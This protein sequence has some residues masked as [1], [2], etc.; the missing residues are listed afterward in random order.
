M[1][2]RMAQPAEP[3]RAPVIQKNDLDIGRIINISVLGIVISFLGYQ[4]IK[5]WR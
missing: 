1:N 2:Y 3:I 5:N 4:L